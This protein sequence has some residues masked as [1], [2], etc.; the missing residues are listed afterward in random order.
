MPLSSSETNAAES[1]SVAPPP[2]EHALFLRACLRAPLRIASIIPSSPAVG[3]AFLRLI[4]LDREGHILELGSGTGPISR[5]L[6]E[7]GIP[8]DRVVL[9]EREPELASYLRRRF[10]AARVVQGDATQITALLEREDVK[11]LAVVVSSLPILWLPLHTQAD[12]LQG[13]FDALGDGG[14]FLQQTNQPVPP[15]AVK[16]LGIYGKRVAAV[17]RNVPPSFIWSYQRA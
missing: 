15:L 13:C 8:P 14:C 5:A 16:K 4:D 9:V 11:R 17:W 2:G 3:R 6:F 1:F 12:L 7:A 10:P